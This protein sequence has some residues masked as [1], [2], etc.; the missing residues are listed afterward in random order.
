MW[1][2]RRPALET[3]PRALIPSDCNNGSWT[4]GLLEKHP[5]SIPCTN[6]SSA[7]GIGR[8]KGVIRYE[9][10][11]I[12]TT[13]ISRAFT[14]L[15]SLRKSQ[16]G[17][18]SPEPSSFR[19]IPRFQSGQTL[20]NEDTWLQIA[21]LSIFFIW[22]YW[23]CCPPRN[24]EC[25]PPSPVPQSIQVFSREP[26]SEPEPSPVEEEV[27]STT[28]EEPVPEEA[29]PRSSSRTRSTDPTRIT[30]TNI[31]RPESVIPDFPLDAPLSPN[32]PRRRGNRTD[33]VTPQ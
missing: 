26:E 18:G 28:E 10:N 1:C 30:P 12:L 25:C 9:G 17:A 4:G 7:V 19:E 33:P 29:L 32:P 21:A 5:R 3:T 16:P 27:D 13:G 15:R 14:F 24:R 20:L 22:G 31:A 11:E 8:P 23:S 2:Y 6:S